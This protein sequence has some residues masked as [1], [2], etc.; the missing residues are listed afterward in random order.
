VEVKTISGDVQLNGGGGELETTTV[1]G[2]VNVDFGTL[3]RARFKSISG[4]LTA[5]LTLAPDG[6]M[7]GESVSGDIHVEFGAAPKAEFDVRT[8]SGD[9]HSCFGPAPETSRHGPGSRLAFDTPGDI[10]AYASRPRAATSGYARPEQRTS[11]PPATV[12]IRANE[13]VDWRWRL[14]SETFQAAGAAGAMRRRQR[15]SVGRGARSR[16]RFSRKLRNM[17]T[18]PEGSGPAGHTIEN[19]RER[20]M[21]RMCAHFRV[22]SVS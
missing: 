19:F 15:F 5:R 22:P 1:S 14:E 18:A 4:D 17:P 6:E 11:R 3:T 9:I 13:R 21:F 2:T 16:D 7:D 8:Y 20:F 12:G 10:R